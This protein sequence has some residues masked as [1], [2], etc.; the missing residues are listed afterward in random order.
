MTSTVARDRFQ[1]TS[2][3]SRI[4]IT[5]NPGHMNTLSE[6]S[7]SRNKFLS[8]CASVGDVS[9]PVDNQFYITLINH[10]NATLLIFDKK[11]T[12]ADQNIFLFT[13]ISTVY[14]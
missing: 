14:F 11:S 1:W 7:I 8:V 10:D 2:N 6:I 3:V 9:Q 4:R 5:D 13:T 12:V